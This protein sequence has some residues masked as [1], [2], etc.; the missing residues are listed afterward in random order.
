VRT[1]GYVNQGV[2]AQAHPYTPTGRGR[3][4]RGG[5][6]LDKSRGHEHGQCRRVGKA[7]DGSL[8]CRS[9]DSSACSSSSTGRAPTTSR[10]TLC[11]AIPRSRCR[12]AQ[13]EATPQACGGEGDDDDCLPDVC[14]SVGAVAAGGSSES[15]SSEDGSSEDEEQLDDGEEEGRSGRTGERRGEGLAF[16]PCIS[17]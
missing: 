12:A 10:Q 17:V 7:V 11:L 15:E 1:R 3:V 14:V 9:R 4:L 2:H 6:L 13:G 8:P 5:G 16:G